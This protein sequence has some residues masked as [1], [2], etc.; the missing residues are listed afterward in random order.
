MDAARAALLL[1]FLAAFLYS[2]AQQGPY[3]QPANGYGT[4]VTTW[5]EDCGVLQLVV[6]QDDRCTL[7]VAAG[8]VRLEANEAE[9]DLG[10][11]AD[12]RAI[13]A[14]VMLRLAGKIQSATPLTVVAPRLRVSGKVSAP[15]LRLQAT[16]LLEVETS[17]E[18]SVEP[19]GRLELHADFVSLVGPVTARGGALHVR[20]RSV[21]H[22]SPICLDAGS[23]CGAGSAS[24]E[25][26]R[27]VGSTQGT[28]LARNPR[29]RGGSIEVLAKTSLFASG[30]FDVSGSVGGAVWLS[31]RDTCLATARLKASG[32]GRA[33]ALRVGTAKRDAGPEGTKDWHAETLLLTSATR[34]EADA[35][36]G[37]AGE[38]VVGAERSTAFN[39]E[40]QVC[41]TQ[42]RGGRVEV[43]SQGDVRYA[44]ELRSQGALDSGRLLL[45]PQNL[46]LDDVNGALAQFTL[47]DP[48]PNGTGYGTTTLPLSG[49]N[50]VVTDPKDNL[51]AVDAGAAYLFNG[52]TGALLSTLTGSTAGDEIGAGVAALTN[53]N[54]VLHSIHWDNGAA[55]NAGA[56]T[57]AGGTSGVGGTVS[58][59]NSLVG[60]KTNDQIGAGVVALKNGNYVVTS[61]RWANGAATF[62]SGAATWGNG[63]TGITGA[64]TDL[65]SLVG[66]NVG[67]Q[68]SRLGIVALENGNYVVRS[69]DWN[70]GPVPDAG[71]ATWGDGSAGVTGAV[72]PA[73]SLVGST[74]G[75]QVSGTGVVALTNGNYV[76][77]TRRW[78]NGAATFAGA[79]TWG[80]GTTGVTGVV[81]AANSL[82]G[83]TAN[84]QVSDTGVVALNNGNYVVRSPNWDNGGVSDAGAATWGDGASGVTGAVSAANSLVGSTTED[85]VSLTGVTGLTNGNY[86]VQSRDWDN[87][88]VRNVGAAT[89]GNGTSGVTGAVSAANSLVGSSQNDLVSTDVVA[90]T[91]GNYVVRSSGWDNGVASGAGAATWGNGSSGIAGAVTASNSLVGTSNTD[92]VS[93]GGV[94][95]LSNGNYVVSSPRWNN[96]T[97]TDAGATTWGDGATGITGAVSAANS[98]VGS[99][100]E[101]EVASAG[102]VGLS[103]G[104]YVVAS[105]NWD[106]GAVPNAGAATW[107]D[108]TTGV[109]GPISTTNSLYGT[110]LG[111]FV[112]LGG[113]FALTNGNYV[114]SSWGWDN[115][116]LQAVG[117]ATWGNGATGITGPVSAANSLIGSS[118]TDRVSLRAGGSPGSNVG[119]VVLK[120]G[121]YVIRSPE[122]DNGPVRDVGAATWGNGSTGVTGVVSAA[123][124]LIGSTENDRVSNTEVIELSNGNYVVRSD[125]WDN[126]A[127]TDAAALSFGAGPGGSVGVVGPANSV[128]G[129]KTSSGTAA[130]AL[131][132]RFVATLKEER[133]AVVFPLETATFALGPG[134]TVVAPTQRITQ[135]LS[136]GT[137]VTLQASQDLTVKSPITVNNPGG[138]GGK[139]TLMAGRNI[140]IEANITT[141]DG[142]LVLIAN[143][144]AAEGVIDADRGPGAALVQ[145]TATINAGSGSLRLET[146]DGAGLTNR[147]RSD[148]VVGT[149]SG[150]AVV[151][152]PFADS[153]NPSPVP[154][155][156]TLTLQGG[157]LG[158]S[159]SIGGVS[160]SIGTI[161]S[162]QATLGVDALT[163]LGTQSV[164][165][166]T[167]GG[168]FA[169]GTITIGFGGGGTSPSPI[170]PPPAPPP[171]QPPPPPPPPSQGAVPPPPKKDDDEL[172][173]NRPFPGGGLWFPAGA[174][175]LGVA[176]PGAVSAA[177]LGLLLVTLLVLRLAA[178]PAPAVLPRTFEQ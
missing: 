146:K 28:L 32:V 48:N 168:D 145:N 153:F 3:S 161:T 122:W 102:V 53:G 99:T 93:S 150:G 157:G 152:V 121:N 97:V 131:G 104:N 36:L 148:Y 42:G 174:C 158:G 117:A 63:T 77:R 120:N 73:N 51:A 24:V 56:A 60:T 163:P 106:N 109:S 142:D 143:A 132:N 33:G 151:I 91:N 62:F 44:G 118:S 126:G 141:D 127:V 1:A 46:T 30:R 147:S 74:G 86:V 61:P 116:A 133:V 178:N 17:G 69:P 87:G 154:P 65:N 59:A 6:L 50:V 66:S 94:I 90:L 105:P 167:T 19:C 111:N 95:A 41:S 16:G 27:Y 165:V 10:P 144:T 140:V 170:P 92:G 75:D 37:D 107:G 123:N 21:L 156:G 79:A 15:A 173:F 103:N 68:V 164:V 130:S 29:G 138:K 47:V 58:A 172:L 43:S 39:G 57:W 177:G 82:V 23:G 100:S 169:L 49:G 64:V 114:V 129:T 166:T 4:S 22:Q 72:S 31:G 85:R 35:V 171:Q 108:G 14:N 26:D 80:N 34:L 162:S 71:A 20:A 139:L 175:S 119:V 135:L 40:I 45:D 160:A 115:G 134:Q 84:D 9:H 101:D 136:A 89:W 125:E 8:R 7:R 38:V 110:A 67:D 25:C 52:T 13:R 149:L 18:V 155:G 12:V 81:S 96:G 11:W 88:P 76:V 83:S 159:F 98:L 55:T 124:S 70:N 78:N 54:Y 128:V 5:R 137:D 112:G 113:V 176:K 2:D